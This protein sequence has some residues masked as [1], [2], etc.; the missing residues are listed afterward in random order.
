MPH[1]P[2]DA[3]AALMTVYM[4]QHPTFFTQFNTTMAAKKLKAAERLHRRRK[5]AAKDLATTKIIMKNLKNLPYRRRN[6]ADECIHAIRASNAGLGRIGR[7]IYG[8]V[9]PGRVNK[10][11]RRNIGLPGSPSTPSLR[12]SQGCLT[13]KQLAVIEVG[14]E[15]ARREAETRY[16]FAKREM[17]R[18]GSAGKRA[19]HTCSQTDMGLAR[20]RLGMNEEI[21]VDGIGPASDEE[22]AHA[23]K[24]FDMYINAEA[25]GGY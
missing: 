4:S 21:V 22:V 25:C 7:T 9:E 23:D 14:M 13:P 5:F 15:V 8:G 17:A 11:Q 16:T 24:Y 10:R 1:E 19:E 12:P 20:L 18:L 2:S 3:R 6:D